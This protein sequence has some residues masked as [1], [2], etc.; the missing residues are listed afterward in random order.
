MGFLSLFEVAGNI[1]FEEEFGRLFLANKSICIEWVKKDDGWF[2]NKLS[3]I[4]GKNCIDPAK[5][6][7]DIIQYEAPQFLCAKI[8]FGFV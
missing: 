2:W 6:W 1:V 8:V 4:E 3:Y 5:T 7:I